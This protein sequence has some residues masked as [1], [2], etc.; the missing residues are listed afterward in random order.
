MRRAALAGLL[1][2]AGCH[3]RDSRKLV[4]V[5]V[6]SQDNPFFK[7]E[8]DAAAARAIELGYRVRVDAHE[9]DAYRQDNLVDAAIASN[10]AVLIL[11]NAGAD[12]S[13]SAIRRAAKAGIAVFLID[14]EINATG[15]AKAQIVSDN[16]QGA[17]LVAAEFARS[18][19]GAGGKSEF[20]ELIGRESDTNA[21]V[22]TKGFH[23]VLD[24]SPWLTIVAAQSANWSQAEAFSKTE[25]I[26]QAHGSIRGI[27]AGND[28]MALGAVAAVKSAGL[29][30]IEIVG[31]D[32]SPDAVAAIEAGEMEA[33][34]LQPAVLISRMA[35]DEADALLKTGSTGKPEVQV[36]PCDLVTKANASEYVNFEKKQ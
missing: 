28:T 31:F 4:A 16:D 18:M 34:A 13:I 36:I 25:T 19:R 6:P 10:A 9:D 22:R 33:T 27:I 32:G 35:V 26:L 24:Q 3:A 20:A 15:I 2:L 23:A 30:G 5:I 29:K 12:A 1:L 14:R 17:R 7:A 8:A 11:D 21:Q